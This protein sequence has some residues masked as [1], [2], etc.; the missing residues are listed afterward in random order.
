MA[1]ALDLAEVQKFLKDCTRPVVRQ[2]LVKLEE[3]LKRQAADD[4]AKKAQEEKAKAKVP[5]PAERPATAPAKAAGNTA[6]PPSLPTGGAWTEISSF[7][8]EAGEYNSDKVKVSVRFEGIGKHPKE[9]IICTFG[10]SQFDL[11]IMNWQGK[12]WRLMKMNLEKEV[13]TDKCSFKVTNNSVYIYL[14]KVKGEFGYPSWTEL[15]EKRPKNATSK[16]NPTAGLM[17]M[18]RD[19]YNDGDDNMRKA[20]GEAMLNAQS[21]QKMDPTMDL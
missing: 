5:A 6:A 15:C 10:K 19:M 4:E 1:A 21:G 9:N 2:H 12:N 16:D 17:D 18:M 14:A 20:I 13:D 3:Q 11:K 7:A 8:F